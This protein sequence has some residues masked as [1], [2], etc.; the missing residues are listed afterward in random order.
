M[1]KAPSFFLISFKVQ[2]FAQFFLVGCMML[3]GFQA[4]IAQTCTEFTE[5][6]GADNPFGGINSSSLNPAFVD[7]DGDED[8]DLF[9]GKPGSTSVIEF[10]EN[11]SQSPDTPE[12]QIGTEN[13]FSIPDFGAYVIVKPTFAYIND[14][15]LFDLIVG[16]SG[17]GSIRYFENSGTAQDAV[18]TEKTGS[19]NPFNDITLTTGFKPAFGDVNGDGN[20]D[21][22]FGIANGKIKY[23]QNSGTNTF[24]ERTGTDNPFDSISL[25]D[26]ATPELGDLDG[27]GDL[28]LIAGSATSLKY[29]QNIGTS[30]SPDFTNICNI[31]GGSNKYFYPAAGNLFGNGYKLAAGSSDSGLDYWSFNS[32]SDIPGDIDGINGVDLADAILGLKI[33]SDID[34]S[35]ETINLSADVNNSQTIDLAEVIFV[36]RELAVP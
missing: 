6:T 2:R 11:V 21:A 25:F 20:I 27:D 18:F 29:Y 30:E 22:V 9:V 33:L 4:A 12:F 28:D 36:L 35:G 13:P 15:L 24:A 31:S 23:F 7:I 32:I 19:E 17:S 8:L 26:S 14:D 5:L 34:V 3:V 1:L 10:Y 16:V